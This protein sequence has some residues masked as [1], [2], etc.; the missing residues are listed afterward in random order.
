MLGSDVAA[1]VIRLKSAKVNVYSI[2]SPLIYN[3]S[4]LVSDCQIEKL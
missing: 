1:D 2:F 3:I 4:N